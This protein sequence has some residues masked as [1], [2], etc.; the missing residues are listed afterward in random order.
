MKRP[1]LKVRLA[2]LLTAAVLG[3]LGFFG[4]AVLAV[5]ALQEWLEDLGWGHPPSEE[6]EH[7]W[8]VLGAMGLVAPLAMVGTAAL[9]WWL[10]GRLL[11]PLRQALAQVK[12]AHA[13]ELDFA[14]PV[15]GEGDEWDVL[16]TTF[17]ALLEDARGSLGR[18]RR[19]TAD[20]A[21]E[22]RTPLTAI[23]GEAEVVLRRERTAEEYRHSLEE[24]RAEATRLA[25]L[26][27]ALL[28]LSRAD[29]GIL[30][31]SPRP[32]A[33]LPLVEAA[34]AR[35]RREAERQGR[36]MDFQ[37]Q[38]D[39]ATVEGDEVLLGRAL[40]NLLTNAVRHG[41]ATVHVRLRQQGAHTVAEVSDDGAGLPEALAARPFERFARG[42]SA[43][44]GEGYGLGL[45][46]TQAIAE[47]HQ[48]SLGYERGAGRSTFRLV[49][50]ALGD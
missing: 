21:H 30:L 18:I 24:V 9:G 41:G 49:L 15:R 4:A 39:P 50:P 25:R 46:I 43:R 40:D 11:S 2:G 48:G 14:L 27:D 12:Q 42:D 35:S 23:I 19:F 22:L 38:A 28:T 36:R 45:S 47:A 26:V 37:L 33:L 16:A 31:S 5:L 29:A 3:A 6:A 17:N 13:A 8:A 34:V 44:T 20:A 10:A 1:S 32:V 7:L